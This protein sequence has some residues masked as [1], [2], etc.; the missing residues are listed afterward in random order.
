[1]AYGKLELMQEMDEWLDKGNSLP[2]PCKYEYLYGRLDPIAK[3]EQDL[4]VY[5]AVVNG[6]K[7]SL[8]VC[9]T[10]ENILGDEVNDYD[11]VYIAGRCYMYDAF[12]RGFAATPAFIHP[13]LFDELC[14]DARLYS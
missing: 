1:M 3:A 8:D 14:E 4:P 2:S 9:A 7:D 13:D 10:V 11:V 12:G 5:V 6:W